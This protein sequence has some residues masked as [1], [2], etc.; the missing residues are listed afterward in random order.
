MISSETFEYVCHE[1]KIIIIIIVIKSCQ[2]ATYTQINS[3]L[4]TTYV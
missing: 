3:S 1:V 2:N 4:F